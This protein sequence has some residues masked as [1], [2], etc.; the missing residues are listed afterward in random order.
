MKYRL[1]LAL[2]AALATAPIG[3][4]TAQPITFDI[5]PVHSGIVFFINHLG[6]SNVIGVAKEFSGEFTF[7]KDAPEASK[8]QAKVKVSSISTNNAQRDSDIQGA[9]WFNA[10]EFP[11]ITF[12]GTKFTKSSDKQGT[13]TGDLTIAGVTKPVTLDV[14]FN[15]QGKN[16]WDGSLEAGFSATAKLKRSD[17]GM[18]ANLPLIGDEVTLR[19]ETEGRGRS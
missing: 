18:T 5:D 4:A 7:D 8:L 16:P 14:T 19:I 2:L 15:G 6:F 11:E 13:I 9:D 1:K 10:T 12:V 17:F 3:P